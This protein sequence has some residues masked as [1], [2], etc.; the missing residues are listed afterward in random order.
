MDQKMRRLIMIVLAL[1]AVYLLYLLLPGIVVVL[2]FVFRVVLPFIIGF[3]IAFILY[4]LVNYL[5][6]QGIPRK[7]SVL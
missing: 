5:N 7:L 4:P 6:K 1:I 3:V 2:K